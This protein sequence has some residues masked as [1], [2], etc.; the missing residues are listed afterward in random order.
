MTATTAVWIALAAAA[1]STAVRALRT[2]P[3]RVPARATVRTTVPSPRADVDGWHPRVTS[4][5]GR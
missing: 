3:A 2:R 4:G 5:C 1:A